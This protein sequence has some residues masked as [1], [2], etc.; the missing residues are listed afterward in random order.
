M[1]KLVVQP[2]K[3]SWHTLDS[4][5][6]LCPFSHQD[7]FVCGWC[8]WVNTGNLTWVCSPAHNLSFTQF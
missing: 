6:L 8:E 3:L 5:A 1:I 4:T 2:V 7:T